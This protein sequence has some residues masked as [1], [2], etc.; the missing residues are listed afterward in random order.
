MKIVITGGPSAG[1]TTIAEVVSRH[2]DMALCPES[3]SILFRGGFPRSA[4]GPGVCYQQV[5]I[6]HV[7]RELEHIVMMKNPGRDLICDRGTLDG[8]AYW[9]D[10]KPRFFERVASTMQ[11]ELLR[12]DWVIDL[13][14]VESGLYKSSELRIETA[15]EAREL[16]L[17]IQ[18]I[19]SCH[20]N[21]VLIRNSEDFGKK[22]KRALLAVQM[23]LEGATADAIRD[24]LE[25]SE[26]A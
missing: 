20:P 22:I 12:Y 21:Y 19:W 4:E 26:V 15:R 25:G 16:D 17:R 18:E 11:N 9:T 13:D 6:Y 3:A 7:Q 1:K 10:T 2:F 5:A 8:L 24:A 14:S 23:M